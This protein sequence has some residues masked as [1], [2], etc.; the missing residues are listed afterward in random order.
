[1]GCVPLQK[2]HE[3]GCEKRESWNKLEPKKG[4][5]DEVRESSRQKKEPQSGFLFGD[6]ENASIE[7]AQEVLD[8]KRIQFDGATVL[9]I[10]TPRL[11]GQLARVFALMLDGKFRTLSQIAGVAGCLE[12]SASARL[13]DLRKARFGSHTVVS[14]QVPGSPLLYEYRL[15]INE[16]KEIDG[17]RNAA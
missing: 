16:R 1:V 14:R 17:R 5:F 9:Q 6:A 8:V 2:L 15:I 13:R 12:T 3:V 7:T 11:A 4:N 10:D